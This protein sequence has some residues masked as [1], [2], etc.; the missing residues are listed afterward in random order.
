LKKLST[1]LFLILFGFSAPS[2]ADDIRDFQ[3]EGMSV[4]DSLL[5]H[6]SKEEIITEIK[7]NKPA[8]NYLTDKFGEVYIFNDENFKT[9]K[10]ASFFV[11]PDDTNYIIYSVRGMLDYIEDIDGCLS[12]QKEIEN[13]ITKILTEFDKRKSNFKSRRDPSGQSTFNQIIFKFKTGD[14]ISISCSNWEE[15]LRKKNN[16]TE[17]LSVIVEKKEVIDWIRKPIN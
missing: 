15:S 16:W 1:Y 9:Y 14:E 8:Y 11:K 13:E 4:G 17:G 3:I 7:K 6:L 12:K 5:N 2:F 10:R